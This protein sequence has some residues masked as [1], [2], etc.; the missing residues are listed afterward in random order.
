LYDDEILDACISCDD[1]KGIQVFEVSKKIFC[2]DNHS[3]GMDYWTCFGD[4]N[5]ATDG[6][7]SKEEIVDC[8][9]LE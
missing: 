9:P 2:L 6:D 3:L 7:D 5:Y 8:V 4:P 1:N